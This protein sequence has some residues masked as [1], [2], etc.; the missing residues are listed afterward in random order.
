MFYVTIVLCLHILQL[1]ANRPL[2]KLDVIKVCG[3]EYLTTEIGFFCQLSSPGPFTK[4]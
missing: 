2:R 4:L 3:I 1:K